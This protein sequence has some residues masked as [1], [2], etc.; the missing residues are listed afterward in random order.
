MD[1]KT[2]LCFLVG[3]VVGAGGAVVTQPEWQHL[4]PAKGTLASYATCIERFQ[5]M[6]DDGAMARKSCT[7]QHVKRLNYPESRN[8]KGALAQGKSRIQ[9]SA[10]PGHA[11]DYERIE[12]TIDVY[13]ESEGGRLVEQY[14]F[15]ATSEGQHPGSTLSGGIEDGDGLEG[16]KWCSDDE[17][18]ERC[19][20]WSVGKLYGL[21]HK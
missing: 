20:S 2:V 14:A 19:L 18:A 21:T 13:E 1:Q 11:Q 6:D 12:G 8:F 4:V 15:I 9:V 10:E 16:L 17:Q 5:N 7:A 3:A